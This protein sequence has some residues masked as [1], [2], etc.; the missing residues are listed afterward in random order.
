MQK[1]HATFMLT[2]RGFAPVIILVG[3]LLLAGVAGGG[4]YFARISPSKPQP[5]NPVITSQT[6]T[7][8]PK[9]ISPLLNTTIKSISFDKDCNI[10]LNRQGSGLDSNYHVI[11]AVKKDCTNSYPP[12]ISSDG[13]YA[14][15][16][17]RMNQ[18]EPDGTISAS[19]SIFVYFADHLLGVRIDN[20]GAAAVKKMIFDKDNNLIVELFYEGND[21]GETKYLVPKIHEKYDDVVENNGEIFYSK[22]FLPKDIIIH[23]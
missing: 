12:Q 18:A 11:R 16:E 2:E 21:V 8:S 4:Y 17:A 5:Q 15:V 20:F 14:V 9:A 1:S 13:K 10:I 22:N 19:N 23:Q 3:V 6:L 7:P